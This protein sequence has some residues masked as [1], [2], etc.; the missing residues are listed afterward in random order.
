MK[1]VM[2]EIAKNAT[3]NIGRLIDNVGKCMAV[4]EHTHRSSKTDCSNS[5]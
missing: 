4:V 1:G 5:S 2:I 3:G